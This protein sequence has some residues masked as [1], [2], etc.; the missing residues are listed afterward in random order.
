MRPVDPA[1]GRPQSAAPAPPSRS[2]LAAPTAIDVSLARRGGRGPG[3]D[4]LRTLP[5]A[6]L[7]IILAA[8]TALSL[9][10]GIR[11][12]LGILMVP[13]TLD[14]PISVADFTLALAV[15]NL[16][17]GLTQP[18]VGALTVR[19]GFRPILIAGAGLYCVGL[20][21]L[22]LAGGRWP[23]L[24]GAGGLIGVAMSCAGPAIAMAITARV[25]PPAVRSFALGVTSAAGSLGAMLA[26]PIGQSLV[27]EF[28]W[29]AGVLGFLALAAILVPAGW[30]AG[31]SDRVAVDEGPS[32]AAGTAGDALAL[33]AREPSFVIMA[34]AYFVCGMQL[35]FITTHLPAYIALCGLDPMLS[36]TALGVIGGANVV[37]SLFFGWAGGRF[38]KLALLAGI[39]LAR[40]VVLTF[41]FTMP[42]TPAST[43]VFAGAM[44]FLWLGVSPLVAGAV[45][46][47]FG[48]RWQAMLQGLAFMGH[49]LGSFVGAFGGGLIFTATG[50]YD[51]AWRIGVSV[52]LAAGLIQLAAAIV[53]PSEAIARAA[54]S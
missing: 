10:M 26:A 53:R 30:I 46:D 47:M 39:Y 24:I 51:L 52:G 14:L 12:S 33:A 18:F 49:Q 29:R 37:G 38:N 3:D 17:W 48:L 50:S 13:L 27:T 1:T 6:T 31:R 40:S 20:A 41:Y 4:P 16:V 23:I 36:A 35:V 25:V 2:V 8:A 44:G 7:L 21:M 43:V 42:A 22:A 19:T 54:P 28:G 11:Q 34:S 15:Q 5:A 9:S 32:R 45:V